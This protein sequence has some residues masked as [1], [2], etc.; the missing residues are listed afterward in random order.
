MKRLQEKINDYHHFSIILI[1]VTVFF[2]LGL[3]FTGA[4]K[5]TEQVALLLCTTYIFIQLAFTL[6]LYSLKWL[7]ELEKGRDD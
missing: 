1:A 3:M 2:Y 6:R 7:R 5:T 4:E